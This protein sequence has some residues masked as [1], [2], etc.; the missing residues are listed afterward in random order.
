MEALV[1]FASERETSLLKDSMRALKRFHKRFPN[2]NKKYLYGI[3]KE[4]AA[5]VDVDEFSEMVGEDVSTVLDGL[6]DIQPHPFYVDPKTQTVGVG[7]VG[8]GSVFFQKVIDTDR[9]KLK[10]YRWWFW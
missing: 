10:S 7:S 6:S 1:Q 4:P 9:A 8:V 5:A 2:A 3:F